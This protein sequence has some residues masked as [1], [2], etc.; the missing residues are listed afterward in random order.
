MEEEEAAAPATA[1]AA[2]GDAGGAGRRRGPRLGRA[3]RANPAPSGTDRRRLSSA[4]R[5][6]CGGM[7]PGRRPGRP[8]GR[9]RTTQTRGLGG[10]RRGEE[11][12]PGKG[13]RGQAGPGE[14]PEGAG[15]AC[16]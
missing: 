12:G 3:R 2:G 10:Q 1:A 13:G 6:R 8:P 5:Q 16:P 4:R 9:P 7:R 11:E 15:C 14:E